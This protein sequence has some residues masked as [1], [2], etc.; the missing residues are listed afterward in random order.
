L[1]DALTEQGQD[2][3]FK[4]GVVRALIHT[5]PRATH[6]YALL[7]LMELIGGLTPDGG[8]TP[9]WN[10]VQR[11]ELDRLEAAGASLRVTAV[12][13]LL[14]Y[15]VDSSLLEFART[16]AL[17]SSDLNFLSLCF[18]IMQQSESRGQACTFFLPVLLRACRDSRDF[19]RVAEEVRS[20][21]LAYLLEDFLRALLADFAEAGLSHNSARLFARALREHAVP[22]V[23][24]RNPIHASMLEI[25]SFTVDGDCDPEQMARSFRALLLHQPLDVGSV[26]D[27][28]VRVWIRLRVSDPQTHWDLTWYDKHHLFAHTVIL[29]RHSGLQDERAI[30]RAD[31]EVDALLANV[32][33]IALAEDRELQAEYKQRLLQ[34]P[35]KHEIA[36]KLPSP[37]KTY[38]HSK[39]GIV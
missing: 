9:V 16:E 34:M 19:V 39:P 32:L 38:V 17:R 12:A 33:N 27:F 2:K 20:L 26:V 7:T 30:L 5:P 21:S 28:A 10:L 6:A 15:G 31:L 36:N 3:A 11:R 22:F 8:R 29:A 23:R 18:R 37:E 24:R 35:L 13:A 25:A 4:D 14:P 1:A